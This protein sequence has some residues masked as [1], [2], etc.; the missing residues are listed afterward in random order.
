MGNIAFPCSIKSLKQLNKVNIAFLHNIEELQFSL[1]NFLLIL[2]DFSKKLRNQFF[3][4]VLIV[5]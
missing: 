5:I 1:S 4:H 2:D 3:G